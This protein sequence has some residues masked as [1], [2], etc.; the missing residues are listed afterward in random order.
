MT[1]ESIMPFGKF[2]GKRMYQ[3]PDWYLLGIE[4]DHEGFFGFVEDK[5]PEV[6]EYIVDNMDAL[7]KNQHR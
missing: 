6:L 2:K 5:Y 3:V 7:T 1:D 4:R